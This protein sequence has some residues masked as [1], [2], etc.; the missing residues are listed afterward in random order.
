MTYVAEFEQWVA[1][2]LEQVFLFFASPTNLPRIMPPSS[3]TEL[4][5][6]KLVPPPGVAPVLSTVTDRDPVAGVGTEIVTAFRLVPFLP[7]RGRW[8]AQITEFE[9]NDHFGDIQKNGPFRRFHHR[10]SFAAETRR[11]VTG[12]VVHDRIEYEIGFG[13]LGDFAQKIFVGRTFQKMFE[14][15]QKKLEAILLQSK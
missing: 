3:G 2:P 15:R 8:I 5:E 6:V 4:L 12:T 14:F 7:F 9:W 1:A 13:I 10:H 11:G